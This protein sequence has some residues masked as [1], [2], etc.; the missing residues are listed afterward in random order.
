MSKHSARDGRWNLPP[1]VGTSAIASGQT[2][3]HVAHGLGV[4]PNMV[5]VTPTAKSTADPTFYLWV[6]T[7]E[8]T[9]VEFVV[10]CQVDPGVLTLPFMWE[11]KRI[12]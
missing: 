3:V 6:P 12:P 7:A 2:H 8:I 10:Y 4:V 9:N 1:R 11:A 5:T